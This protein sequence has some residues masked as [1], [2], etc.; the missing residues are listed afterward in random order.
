MR[1]RTEFFQLAIIL[2]FLAAW[3]PAAPVGTAFTYQGHLA[4][5]GG[6]LNGTAD[7]EFTLWDEAGSGEPPTGGAQVSSVVAINDITI[8]DGLFTV[9]LDFGIEAFH[10]EARWLQVAVRSPHDGSDTEPFTTLSPRQPLTAVPHALHSISTGSLQGHAVSTMNPAVGQVLKW[11]GSQ[12]VPAME[13]DTT[14][15]AGAGLTLSN[16]I[17]GVAFAGDGR[18]NTVARSD[19]LHDDR[20]YTQ[21]QSEDLFA[22]IDHDHDDVYQRKYARTLV[23]SPVGTPADN[24]NMLRNTVASIFGASSANPYLV[25]IE[26]GIYD[27]GINDLVL[28]AHM[29]LEGSGELRTLIRGTRSSGSWLT[30]SALV[31]GANNTEVRFLT[32][33]NSGVPGGFST[34]GYRLSSGSAR[35]TNVTVRAS[36]PNY[37]AA[38]IIHSLNSTDAVLN[39]VTSHA[40]GDGTRVS[41]FESWGTSSIG[42]RVT[43]RNSVL[44]GIGANSYGVYGTTNGVSPAYP[45]NEV[46][47][48]NSQI[49][50]ASHTL[51]TNQTYDM[52]I[53]ASQLIGGPGTGSGIRVCAGVYDEEFNF[54]TGPACP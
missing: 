26:P 31:V 17:F 15:M 46:R 24:G 28:K 44:T 53:A 18:A 49:T 20:Y 38:L 2:V 25:R 16:T 52:R 29:D 37:V 14:Y 27:L 23:V 48:Y 34:V 54:I 45:L 3:L 10:G 39:N 9:S 13:T 12:W 19:H 41:G 33:E 7:L 11:N 6:S 36:G 32:I 40:S 50:G 51:H 1:L 35:L 22:P 47:V 43:I 21:A 30:V 4:D 8:V 42:V 5:A